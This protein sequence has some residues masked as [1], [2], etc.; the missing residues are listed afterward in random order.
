MTIATVDLEMSKLISTI[1]RL[2]DR[3]ICKWKNEKKKKKSKVT[4]YTDFDSRQL[5][6]GKLYRHKVDL[7]LLIITEVFI[8][9][10]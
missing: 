6:G 4:D 7:V 3:S 5:V 1:S 9:N 2:K 8:S 10:Y